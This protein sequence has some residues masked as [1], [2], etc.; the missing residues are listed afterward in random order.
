MHLHIMKSE[1]SKQAQQS[2]QHEMGRSIEAMLDALPWATVDDAEKLLQQNGSERFADLPENLTEDELLR[3]AAGDV[4]RNCA[5]KPRKAGA[6]EQ[7][8][9]ARE[10]NARHASLNEQ[11]AYLKERI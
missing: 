2:N 10:P 4:A 3:L 1:R 5:K 8:K 7:Q 6:G 11:A 9:R